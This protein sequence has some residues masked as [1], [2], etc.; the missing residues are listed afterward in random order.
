MRLSQL[1]HELEELL[2]QEDVFVRDPEVKMYDSYGG[3]R[4]LESVRVD[5]IPTSPDGEGERVP[6]V[7]LLPV[8]L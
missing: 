7:Q 6:E 1:R 3:I 2:N 4:D 8:L 5:R